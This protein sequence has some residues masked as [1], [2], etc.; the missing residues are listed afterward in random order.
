MISDEYDLLEMVGKGSMG[1][2]RKVFHRKT[3]TFRAMKSILRDRLTED[4][5]AQ[6]LNDLTVYENIQHPNLVKLYNYYYDEY[7]IYIITEYLEGGELLD[8][9]I[10]VKQFSE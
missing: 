3:G 10:F 7:A 1:D 6:I 9:I 8:R 4:Q 2:V 5:Q